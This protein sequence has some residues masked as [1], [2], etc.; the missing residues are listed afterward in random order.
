MNLLNPEKKKE[1]TLTFA[2]LAGMVGELGFIIAIPLIITILAGIWLDKKFNT[3]PLFMI[4]GILLAITTSTIAIGRK[5][6]RLNKI[7]GI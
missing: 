1:N 3:I 7:N 5:I 2:M 6:K 4:V